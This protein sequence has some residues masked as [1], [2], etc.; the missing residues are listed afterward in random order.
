LRF[1]NYA[2]KAQKRL[3]GLQASCGLAR[4]EC[5]FKIRIA[6]IANF[7]SHFRGMAIKGWGAFPCADR[8][9]TMRPEI[10]PSRI[11]II[12]IRNLSLHF[13]HTRRTMRP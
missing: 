9:T 12:A 8:R 4:Q 10:L 7:F 2:G 5:K 11:T 6:G 13:E 3:R 1:K